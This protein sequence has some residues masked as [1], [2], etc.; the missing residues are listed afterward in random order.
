MPNRSN[1]CCMQV[2]V[3]R[4]TCYSP[5]MRFIHKNK[6]SAAAAFTC[7]APPSISNKWGSFDSCFLQRTD[8]STYKQCPCLL[9]DEI[10]LHM[11]PH[12][13]GMLPIQSPCPTA[14]SVHV[15]TLCPT[16]SVYVTDKQEF[17]F[18]YKKYSFNALYLI[19]NDL[20]PSP[21]FGVN[22]MTGLN[23]VCRCD[24]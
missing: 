15:T 1:T 11:L 12:Y 9:A 14:F 20:P 10:M 3:L 2:L 19:K 7:W 16:V 23:K 4:M 24:G 18:L 6:T 21:L 5:A 22:V 8:P 13:Q 17:R